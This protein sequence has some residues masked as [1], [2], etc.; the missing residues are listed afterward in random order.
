M[1]LD[2]FF[3]DLTGLDHPYAD[4]K[5]YLAEN[6]IQN[7]PLRPNEMLWI[8]DTVHDAEVAASAGV[9]CILVS[10]GHQ[11]TARLEETNCPVLPSLYEIEELL[12]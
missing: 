10:N 3:T 6:W 2:D 12:F 11:D 4:G 7:Q 5:K 8:G 1:G 9:S